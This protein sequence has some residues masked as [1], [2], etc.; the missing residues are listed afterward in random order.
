MLRPREGSMFENEEWNESGF[1]EALGENADAPDKH[2]VERSVG[3]TSS[4]VAHNTGVTG[5]AIDNGR[6]DTSP[7]MKYKD[8]KITSPNIL[9]KRKVN[10]TSIDHDSIGKAESVPQADMRASSDKSKA[11]AAQLKESRIYTEMHHFNQGDG[12]AEDRDVQ[13]SELSH[14]GIIQ[15]LEGQHVRIENGSTVVNRPVEQVSGDNITNI[16]EGQNSLH[17][18]DVMAMPDIGRANRSSRKKYSQDDVTDDGDVH[19]HIGSIHVRAQDQ[20]KAQ[21]VPVPHRETGMA[22]QKRSDGAPSLDDYLKQQ[23][24]V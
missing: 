10:E 4:S 24:K 19:I 13:N 18:N 15:Y 21:L 14:Q 9:M 23:E 2:H 16:I 8:D 6:A 7:D 3:R 5:G 20:G 11:P 1:D 22:V 12:T 17:R